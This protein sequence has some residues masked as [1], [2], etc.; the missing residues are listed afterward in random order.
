MPVGAASA[1]AFDGTPWRGAR[2]R[3]PRPCARSRRPR[4]RGPRPAAASATKSVP[5]GPTAIPVGSPSPRRRP[6]RSARR[7]PRAARGRCRRRRS[8]AARRRRR[9]PPRGRAAAPPPRAA[10]ARDPGVPSP[11]SV[12]IVP[13]VPTRR[14]RCWLVSAI[15]SE[16]SG[17]IGDAR[18]D[19]KPRRG[20]GA[21]VAER[22]APAGH[23]REPPVGA[24][25]RGPGSRRCRRCTPRGR[26]RRGPAAR[27]AAPRWR[28]P[29][30]SD[31]R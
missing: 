30:S 24:D 2:C 12:V 15:A 5:P 13:S 16:P 26:R 18:S 17:A 10:V 6:S 23:G 11:A 9:R 28:A 29:P 21:V 27:T 22:G 4:R 3:R 7:R 14:T 8:A 25:P 1:T 19:P 31:E 20:R